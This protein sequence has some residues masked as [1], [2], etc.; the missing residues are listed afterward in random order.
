[1]GPLISSGAVGHRPRA[2]EASLSLGGLDEAQQQHHTSLSS[3]V[4]PYHG[5][6]FRD[7]A[8]LYYYNRTLVFSCNS[9]AHGTSRHA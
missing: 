6:P 5:T 4:S 9:T 8:S 2:R 3:A 7:L 1:M